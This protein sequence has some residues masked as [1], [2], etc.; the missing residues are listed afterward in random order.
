MRSGAALRSGPQL[1]SFDH[2]I[3]PHFIT[4]SSSLYTTISN[5]NPNANPNTNPNPNHIP[6]PNPKPSPN[7]NP[8]PTV[9]SD[10]QIGPVDPQIVTIQL[11]SAAP[12][13][14]A[15]CRVPSIGRSAV[16]L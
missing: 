4:F 1:V 3:D 15:F 13:R 12:P 14:S 10:P 6:N 9:V 2:V 5:P 16:E 7:P 8:N 11:R